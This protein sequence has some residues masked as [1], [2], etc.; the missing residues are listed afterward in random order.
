M[1][2]LHL[3]LIIVIPSCTASPAH[4]WIVFRSCK[5]ELLVTRQFDHITPVLKELHWLPVE[6]RV[7]YK[8]ILMCFKCLHGLAPEYLCEL[9]KWHSPNRRLRSES[10]HLVAEQSWNLKT[11]GYR[12]FAVAAPRLWNQL[13][14]PLRSMEELSHFQAGLKAHLFSKEFH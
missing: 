9:I 8:V 11:F 14:L 12:R 7:E 10:Q 1:G 4:H 2:S 5:I 3:D 13:P 6:R